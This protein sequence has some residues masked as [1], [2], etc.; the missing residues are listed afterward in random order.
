MASY[1]L[2]VMCARNIF[3]DMNMRWHV[4]E[5]PIHV[6]FNVLWENRYK[7]SYSLICDELIARIYFIIFKKECPRQSAATKKMISKVGHWYLDEQDTYI[8]V[9]GATKEPHLLQ[10]HVPNRLVVGE[11]CYQTIFQGYNATLVKKRA[12]NPY[13][14]HVGFYLFKDTNQAKQEG[15]SQLKFRF[16]IGQF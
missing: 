3:A 11:I 9:L 16:H 12:F 4:I 14:F 10:A 1:L 5:L 2:D 6:Y 13:G 7:S 15:M 8:R